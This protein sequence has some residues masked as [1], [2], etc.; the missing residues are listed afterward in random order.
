MIELS[1]T[2]AALSRIF[3]SSRYPA[4]DNLPVPAELVRQWKESL[5]LFVFLIDAKCYRSI[6]PD[7]IMSGRPQF[8]AIILPVQLKFSL[9]VI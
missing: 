8:F 6:I 9:Q 1:Q 3:S 4:N 7:Q 5:C 2:L